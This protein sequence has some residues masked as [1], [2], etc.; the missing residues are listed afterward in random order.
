MATILGYDSKLNKQF[1][2]YY[3]TAI[4]EYKPNEVVKTDRTDEGRRIEGLNCPSCGEFHRTN[5]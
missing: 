2:C 5:N 4:V 1:T 3:C